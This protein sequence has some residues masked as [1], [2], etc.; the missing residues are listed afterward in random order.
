MISEKGGHYGTLK[1]SVFI[2]IGVVFRLK[3]A[4]FSTWKTLMGYTNFP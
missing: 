3:S 2:E 4:I 1:I